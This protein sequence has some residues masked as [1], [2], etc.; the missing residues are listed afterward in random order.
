MNL[1]ERLLKKDNMQSTKTL[2]TA[3]TMIDA[4]I[5]TVWELWT[6]P[7]HI[8]IW[9]N[10]SEEWHTPRAENDLRIGGKLFLRMEKKDGSEGFDYEC[11]Y[12]D[13]VVNKKISHTTSDNRKTT[14]F[15][16]QVISVKMN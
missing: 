7:Q 10:T 15:L 1:K 4:P 5:D 6:K 3:E 9:N 12:D 13:V 14:I 11:I 8:M 2:L 16:K